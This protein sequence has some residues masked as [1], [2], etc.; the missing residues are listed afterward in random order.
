MKSAVYQISE[1]VMSGR[2]GREGKKR[3]MVCNGGKQQQQGQRE[4]RP[5]GK[6][7]EDG[8]VSTNLLSSGRDHSLD[9]E[10]GW[11]KT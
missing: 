1:G 7:C 10:V 4:E 9:K 11:M 3:Q 6:E 8:K 2:K 5:N